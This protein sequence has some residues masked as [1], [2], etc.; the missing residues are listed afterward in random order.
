MP[1]M[2]WARE[3]SLNSVINSLPRD[4]RMFLKAWGMTMK[5]MVSKYPRPR[6]R[7]ASDWPAS[8][9]INPP[10]MISAT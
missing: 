2:A 3:V 4:G 7:P 1:P 9:L 5:R 6:E 8:T 10:R